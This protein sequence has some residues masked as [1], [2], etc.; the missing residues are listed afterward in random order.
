[1]SKGTSHRLHPPPGSRVRV[2]VLCDAHCDG[3]AAPVPEAACGCGLASKGKPRGEAATLVQI[4]VSC[5]HPTLIVDFPF[6]RRVAPPLFVGLH[7][8]CS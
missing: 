6:V 7:P 2:S 4:M 3:V 5:L 8:L 1:M